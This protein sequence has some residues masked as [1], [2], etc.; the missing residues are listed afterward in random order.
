MGPRSHNHG[1]IHHFL[2][3]KIDKTH[4]IYHYNYVR[5][6]LFI[7]LDVLSILEAQHEVM[8]SMGGH[9]SLRFDR[10]SH[11]VR[12]RQIYKVRD[13]SHRGTSRR[14]SGYALVQFIHPKC[15]SILDP[16][17]SNRNRVHNSVV[18]IKELV[19][20][21]LYFNDRVILFNKRHLLL[22]RG[23]PK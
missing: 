7:I 1:W 12:S 3:Q 4:N 20:D 21:N 2:R 17:I 15:D 10:A 18:Q 9:Y 23:I 5:Y 13:S 8:G 19:L 14:I 6:I 11:R 22:H 16:H